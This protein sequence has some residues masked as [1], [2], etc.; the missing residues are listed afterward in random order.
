MAV[1][2]TTTQKRYT[3]TGTAAAYPIDFQFLDTQD[4]RVFVTDADGTAELSYGVDF[5]ISGGDGATGAASLTLTYDASFEILLRRSTAII[6]EASFIETGSFSPQ[7]LERQLDRMVMIQQELG[8]I[9]VSST[10]RV[11]SDSDSP[12]PADA[13]SPADTVLGYDG[14]GTFLLIPRSEVG[15]QGPQGFQGYQGAT[16]SDGAQGLQGSTGPQGLQGQNGP[17][18]FQGATGAQGPQGN[19]G[20]AGSTGGTGMMGSQGPQGFQGSAGIAWVIGS[21]PDYNWFFDGFDSGVSAHGLQ[22]VQGFQGDKGAIIE[23]RLSPTGFARLTCIEAPETRFEDVQLLN[24]KGGETRIA[25]PAQFVEA[26]NPDSIMLS[27]I[28]VQRTG[29]TVTGWIT[30]GEAFLTANKETGIVITYTGIRKGFGK[31]F[32]PMTK[33]EFEHNLRFWSEQFP[34]K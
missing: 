30:G 7:A 34:S 23:S 14:A 27:G 25:L 24:V 10:Y 22:G 13:S 12:E 32:E 17:Q 18:G 15:S 31:R 33:E 8:S 11:D 16:G 21:A 5:T 19:Q 28:V 3:G 9:D 6:Q 20:A 1:S 26:C 29:A 4:I 2:T